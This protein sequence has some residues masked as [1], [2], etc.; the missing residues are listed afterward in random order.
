MTRQSAILSGAVAAWLLMVIGTCVL[1][2]PQHWRAGLAM[3]IGELALG[4][5]LLRVVGRVPLLVRA[6]CFSIG[7]YRGP[8]PLA[9]VPDPAVRNPV[10]TARDVDDV[11][12]AFVADPF[13]LRRDALWWMFFEVLDRATGKGVI[14]VARSADTRRWEYG[15][16]VLREPFHLSYPYVFE[17]DGTCY[18]VPETHEA[19]VVRLYRARHFPGQWEPVAD[20]LSGEYVDPSLFQHQGSWWLYAAQTPARCNTLRLFMA[21]H[22]TGPWREHPRSPVIAGDP[23]HAR[24]AGRVLVLEHGRILRFAQDHS[25]PTRGRRV[26]AFE[27]K[28]LTRLDYTETPALDHPALE[29][30]G[31]GWNAV[32][33]HQIDACPDGAGGW[34]ACVDGFRNRWKAT[35]HP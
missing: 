32:G 5:L 16:V 31:R 14:A 20:L 8:G 33:M 2:V 10:L 23:R 21:D 11:R 28:Q 15:Q 3:G 12:A 26:W 24:P 19:G 22:L 30:T 7:V 4:V 34:V 18:M 1:V 6:S 27:V 9:L 29:A 35:L 25:P 13:L 17:C